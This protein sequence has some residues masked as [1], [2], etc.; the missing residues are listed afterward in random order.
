[1]NLSMELL[2]LLALVV[3]IGI[4]YI[5]KIN[6]GLLAMSF[7][8]MTGAFMMNLGVGE[9][10]MM[11]PIKIFFILF[12]VTL[13]YSFA[14]YNG[15]LEKIAMHTLYTCRKAP[16][17]LPIVICFL[18][19]LLA[20]IGAGV[21]AVVAFMGPITM[22]LAEKSGM[23]RVLGAISVA[24]GA[25][26]GSNF[27]FSVSGVVIRE[28]IEKNGFAEQAPAYTVAIFLNALVVLGL[29]FAIAYL[30]LKGYKK[31]TTELTIEK[32]QPFS[33][34]QRINLFLI[35]GMI[36]VLI[37]PN[38]IS[39]FL[40]HVPL[41]ILLKKKLDIGFLA[42]IGTVVALT[43][44]LGN[45]KQVVR[46]LPWGTM[47]LISG[48]GVLMEVAIRAGTIKMLASWVGGNVPAVLI[49]MVSIIAA[50]GMAFFSST[51]GV[52]LPTLYPIV[53]GIAK[54]AGLDPSFL[55]SIILLGGCAGGAS[56]FSA[57]MAMLLASVPDEE[58]RTH[59]FPRFLALVPC[60]L[61]ATIV[62]VYLGIIH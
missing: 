50:G 32:P 55:F 17:M 62:F 15:T 26:A 58:T 3:S 39:M 20:M 9:I 49:P 29:E 34:E 2:I 59:L 22:I 37:I 46:N 30:L 40:P 54:T 24:L 13:F 1:V 45:E 23:N 21:Y 56:P 41:L 25:T 14:T 7:A 53:P 33:R 28:L 44:K 42:V 18:S 31:G 8:Y 10:I 43:L 38:V 6:I 61:F 11:W 27:M 4:G 16:T 57:V 35:L 47:I 60:F 51:L 48:V 5:F 19:M 12:S 52:V 36:F